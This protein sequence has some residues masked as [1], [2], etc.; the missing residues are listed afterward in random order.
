MHLQTSLHLCAFLM[1]L[2]LATHVQAAD[3]PSRGDLLS[4]TPIAQL[5]EEDLD[6]KYAPKNLEADNGVVIYRIVYE[7]QTPT[8]EAVQASGLIVVPSTGASSFP[9]I[10]LQHGTLTG[11]SEAPS[12][13][14]F[15]GIYEGAKGFVTVVPDYL[16]FGNSAQLI[17]PYL[18][19]QG[20][21]DSTI[22]MMRAARKFAEGQ[23]VSL[24]ALFLKGY[25]EGGYATFVLQK[26]LET[27]YASEFPLTAS[28]PSAGP[29]NM[30]ALALGS[31]AAPT[32]TAFATA[33]IIFSMQKWANHS[34]DLSQIFAAD[35][36]DLMALI[37]SDKLA[38]ER[39]DPTPTAEL[40]KSAFIGEFLKP[41]STDQQA[42]LLR[43][44]FAQV[45]LT[46]DTWV[47]KVPTRLYHC[48]EDE[49]VNVAFTQ[50]MAEHLHQLDVNA[51]ISTQYEVS[52]DS[53]KPY[54]HMSC[55][56]Y[57]SAASWFKEI[58]AK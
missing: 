15:E 53:S 21:I 30:E 31:F 14:P 55:P 17:H 42:L 38:P 11:K 32:Q 20:Y 34:L 39:L 43:T 44:L 41:D 29:Y 50:Q 6:A 49:L 45:N 4:A 25:S 24:D 33:S 2:T 26:E 19:P 36:D 48:P 46:R 56:L 9:W 28:S 35:L 3:K 13:Q 7:T 18:L 52:P 12:L 22:D 10:T 8:G 1:P 23:K 47:P 37:S 58:L 57:Y 54:T 51:P 27:N 16:G 5:S 40:L